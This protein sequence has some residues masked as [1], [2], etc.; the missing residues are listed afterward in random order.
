MSTVHPHLWSAIGLGAFI[1]SLPVLL[2]LIHPG[3][4]STRHTIAAGQMLMSALLIHV[5]GGRIEM[6]FHI[7][8]SLAFL[9][10]YRDWRVLVTASVV[11]A[12]DHLLLGAILP[13]S[14]YGMVA[15]ATWRWAEHAG[16]V[17]F[18]SGFLIW[19]CD[20]NVNEMRGIAARQTELEETNVVVEAA[21]AEVRAGVEALREAHD[22]LEE[23]VRE[24]TRELEQALQQV[25]RHSAE[26]AEAR[27]AALA[28]THAKSQFLANM[29]HEIR[30]PMN[31]VL[32]MTELLLSTDLHP[33]QRDFAETVYHSG[34][35]LLAI[36]ND[37]LDFSK[38][39]A[40]KLDIET[41]FFPLRKTVE[42]VIDL[43]GERA[44]KK[45]LELMINVDSQIPDT[46]QGD[47]GRLRQILTNLIG[48]AIK[49][50]DSGEV[51]LEIK[52]VECDNNGPTGTALLHC[53][54]TDTGIGI[55]P[56]AQ[57]RLFQSFSQVDAS[58]TRRYG[59][60]GLGL[61]ICQQLCQM[62][63][64]EIG[65]QS[66]L[67]K[68]S[69]F[70]FKIRLGIPAEQKRA[71]HTADASTVVKVEEGKSSVLQGKRVLVVDDN[72]TNRRILF[73]QM[74]QWGMQADL[75]ETAAIA[76]R[77]IRTAGQSTGYDIAVLDYQMPEMD[78]FDLAQA[79]RSSQETRGLPLVMLTSY[80]QR[81]HQARA[82]F[83]G[84][85]GYL[86]KPV[87]MTQLHALLISTMEDHLSVPSG[88]PI[89]APPTGPPPKAEVRLDKGQVLIAEDNTVNQK[90]A[91]LQV[92]RLGYKAVVVVNGREALA[93][94]E[95][96]HFDAIL[97]D[98]QMPEMDGFEAASA[99][100]AMETSGASK[101]IPIIALTANALAGEDQVCIDSGMDDYMSKPLKSDTLQAMLEKWIPSGETPPSP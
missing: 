61:A 28:A 43:L 32:G 90:V 64:G 57:E 10:F 86:A 93:A 58:T 52:P 55:P 100:R 62:M 4:R 11:T 92:E 24:R 71:M 46:V 69:T 84:I 39:E 1:V 31:G 42:E 65:V 16:W 97:M 67:G 21:N 3:K 19:S 101:H 45:G 88:V 50:T 5:S 54:V 36:I 73:H 60:S 81:G 35:A 89:T 2:A 27:D 59:G 6:H 48:N 14:V 85:N 29:S 80:S 76:L 23:R 44:E 95:H 56:A 40:G 13:E 68:G 79:I 34:E 99:I 41:I 82:E 33:E 51:L 96:T 53:A 83:I 78:G 20:R 25:E 74:T 98:C 77:M 66:E 37:I 91:R 7:F 26:I 22:K 49:F 63:G 30:T 47:P 75:A 38:I 15:G 87:R 70:W 17:L 72:S 94:L 9:A 12:L 8:G 18:E